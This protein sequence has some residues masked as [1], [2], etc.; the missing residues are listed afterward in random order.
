[1]GEKTQGGIRLIAKATGTV[2]KELDSSVKVDEWT[3]TIE[4]TIVCANYRYYAWAAD[5]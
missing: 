1:M 4:N 2:K 5:A 3:V